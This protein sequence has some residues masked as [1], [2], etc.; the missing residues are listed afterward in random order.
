[1]ATKFDIEK[2]IEHSDKRF[3]KMDEHIVKLQTILIPHTQA[4]TELN[5]RTNNLNVNFS[6]LENIRRTE[7]KTLNGKL[8]AISNGQDMIKEHI[9]EIKKLISNKK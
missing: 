1:L 3:E 6:R 2:I 9:K 7:F 5:K 8:E 4:L